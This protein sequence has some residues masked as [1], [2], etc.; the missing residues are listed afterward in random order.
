MKLTLLV[1]LALFLSQLATAESP[2]L[3]SDYEFAS[4]REKFVA[5]TMD[6]WDQTNSYLKYR[7]ASKNTGRCIEKFKVSMNENRFSA[8]LVKKFHVSFD[9]EDIDSGQLVRKVLDTSP[10]I[11]VVYEDNTLVI[12]K[13]G[14]EYCYLDAR[15]AG[16][17]E[18]I[19]YTC[20]LHNEDLR[21]TNLEGV[22]RV[23]IEGIVPFFGRET[24]LYVKDR[25]LR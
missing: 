17:G 10:D 11:S 3:G 1:M 7:L 2:E 12:R 15:I 24:C 6:G 8:P 13:R 9:Y 25:R 4:I 18:T 21:I 19:P 20:G 16:H 23:E 14:W 5:I 22:M